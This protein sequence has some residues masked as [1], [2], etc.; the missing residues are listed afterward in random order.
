MTL[1]ARVSAYEATDRK[2]REDLR[3]YCAKLVRIQPKSGGEP[4]PFKW[5]AAQVELH[6]KLERQLDARGLV[7]AIILKA[8]RLGIST[9][10]GARFY[11]KATL[12]LGKNAFI[13]THHDKSTAELYELVRM[14]H[15]HVPDDYRPGTVASNDNELAFADMDGGYRVGT[16]Q[17]VHGLGRGMTLQLFHGS[18]VAFWAQAHQHFAGVMKAVSLVPGTEMILE[19]TA[20]GVGGEFYKQWGLAERGQSDFI[21]IFL[22]WY[23]DPDNARPLPSDYEPSAEEEEYQRLYKLTDEQLCWAHYDNVALGGEPGVF[24]LKFRQENPACAAEAFQTTGTDSLIPSEAVLRARRL[25]VGPKTYRSLPRVLG[26]DVAR[27][28][29]DRTRLIDRQ[30][31]KA[32]RIN[33]VMHTDDLLQIAHRVMTTL[34][35]NPDIRRAFIDITGVGAGVYDICRNNGFDGRVAGV[36]YG[37]GAM[38][39]TLYINRRAEM[40]GRMKSWFLDP[41]GADIPDDDEWQRHITA[42]GFKWDAN[43]RLQLEKKED[44]KKRLGFSPDCGDALGQTFAEILTIEEPD[45]R[46]K[47]MREH[48][49]GEDGGGDWQTT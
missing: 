10:V 15:A 38:E 49:D 2:M 26:V 3:H 44:I 5:N 20:N 37:S 23:I 12:Q 28:G 9:Y 25:E 30:G 35:D 17:N 42:P 19:S 22:P 18:E 11:N 40:W 48:M 45:D 4:I 6:K 41:G 46:P 21:P 32:G 39:P 7:R 31:R 27:G 47:W 13:L 29:G 33:E 8:R 34:R 36:N 24:C 14:I 43:S 16:A 1:S